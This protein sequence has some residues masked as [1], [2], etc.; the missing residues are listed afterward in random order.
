MARTLRLMLGWRFFFFFFL[1]MHACR[2]NIWRRA[3]CNGIVCSSQLEF[4]ANGR[5]SLPC[6]H[7][8]P[9]FCTRYPTGSRPRISAPVDGILTWAAAGT[10][11]ELDRGGCVCPVC[12]Q[13]YSTPG[14]L[15][16]HMQLHRLDRRTFSCSLCPCRF[17]WPDSLRRH[18]VKMHPSHA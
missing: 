3:F 15:K 4:M 11:E 18:V 2:Q 10:V 13:S 14:S 17:S 8:G 12:S 16:R 6:Y 7:L 9:W 1:C 5:C